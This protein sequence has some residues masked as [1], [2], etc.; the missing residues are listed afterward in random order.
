MTMM[1]L[2]EFA[3]HMDVSLG[4]VQKAIKSGRITVD[5]SGKI[6]S[7]RAARDWARNTDEGRKSYTDLSR[8]RQIGKAV[9][10]AA[11][12][13]DDDMPAAG[14]EGGED[15]DVQRYRKA[16][17]EREEIRAERERHEL[18][19]Q[20]G[21]LLDLEEANR[22]VFTAFRTLRDAMLNMA[23][24]IKAQCAAET[25][26]GRVERLLTGEIES[27]LGAIDI[28]K[29]LREGGEEEEDDGGA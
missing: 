26:E 28:A 22:M 19:L 15:P 10:V 9:G 8:R 25:D 17:A 4:A 11:G 3:R 27:A 1:G 23:V 20:Q 24:R 14:A 2:R 13:D 7:E 18:E 5:D 21:S 12:D 16:R 29:V 6:D